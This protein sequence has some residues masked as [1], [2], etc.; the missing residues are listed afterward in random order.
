LTIVWSLPEHREA[1]RTERDAATERFGR[2]PLKARAK[3]DRGAETAASIYRRRRL[4]GGKLAAASER[5]EARSPRAHGSCIA[6]LCEGPRR[7]N[8]MLYTIAVILLVL[9]VL[10]LVTG[11]TIGAFIHVLLVIAVVLL[12]VGLVTGRRVV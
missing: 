1:Q 9:W 7:E 12:L 2:L 10:G 3:P 11:Y 8:V 4:S 6:V 5:C